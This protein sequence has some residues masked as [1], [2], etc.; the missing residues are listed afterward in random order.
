[1]KIFISI[2]L[3]LILF[4]SIGYAQEE[5]EP[6]VTFKNGV[7]IVHPDSIFSLN[8]RFRLQARGTYTTYSGEDLEVETVEARIRRMRIRFEGFMLNPKLT[9][10]IQLSFS[11]G[12]MAWNGIENSIY[13]NSPNI[14]RDAI[15]N[16]KITTRITLGFGQTKLPGNRQRVVSSGELQFPDRALTNTFYTIDRDFGLFGTYTGEISSMVYLLK[17]VVSTGEGRNSEISDNGLAYTGRVELLPFGSFTNNGD[18]FEGDLEREKTPKLSIA[19]GYSYNAKARRTRGTTGSDLYEL[20]D[21]ESILIDVLFKYKGWAIS[22]EYL[23]RN[24]DNPITTHNDGRIRT[25]VIGRGNLYQVSYFFRNNFEIAGRYA[26]SIPNEKV[27][28][29]QRQFE[30]LT[31]GVTKYLRRH[32]VKLQFDLTYGKTIDLT[33]DTKS[34]YWSPRFQIELGI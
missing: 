29:Y 23:T 22:C 31:W 34:D 24:T 4:L 30:E 19:G 25:V 9:Y 5:K 11:R 17:G 18:Y 26:I 27:Y 8:F 20:R 21:L 16:Y 14:V 3:I 32:R 1:M 2:C 10:Y 12:D 7:G 15:I 28:S 6:Q 13:N 33:T